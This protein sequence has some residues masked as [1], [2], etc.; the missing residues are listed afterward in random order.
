MS[1]LHSP[2]STPPDAAY[3]EPT[4]TKLA[5]PPAWWIGTEQ[6]LAAALRYRARGWSV[7]PLEPNGKKPL[8]KWQPFQTE[9]PHA[10]LLEAWWSEHKQANCGI[11]TGTVSGLVVLDVDGELGQASIADKHLPPTPVA[12]TAKGRHYY[13]RYPGGQP[14][15]NFARRLPGLDLR[16]EGGYVV[17]PPSIHA[18]GQR[19][20]WAE[21]L[22]P[23]DVELAPLPQWIVDLTK[24]ATTM[25]MTT[26]AAWAELLAC[27]VE[28]GQRNDTAARLAGHL[29]GKGLLEAEV[30][31][32]LLG[33][34]E[35]NKPPLAADEVQAVVS[36]VGK[37]EARKPTTT[38]TTITAQELMSREFPAPRW[39]VPGLLP[40][41][42][43]ILAGRPKQ[44][45]SFLALAWGIATATGG[46]ALG[47]EQVEQGSALYAAL[48]DSPRRLQERLV[49]LLGD[50]EDP[51]AKLHFV[52]RLP[53]LDQGGLE[54]LESWCSEHPDTRL[55]ALDTYAKARPPRRRESDL[56]QYDSDQ[57][58]ILQQFAFDHHLCLLVVH[59]ERKGL[60]D[61]WL[62]AVSGSTGL[63]GAADA[64]LLLRRARG[65]AD[66]ELLVTGRDMEEQSL[67]LRFDR[68]CWQLLGK[69]E[70]VQLSERR[71][72]IL[73]A[74][75]LAR[76]QGRRLTPKQIADELGAERSTVRKALS[77]MIADHQVTCEGD[78]YSP[79]SDDE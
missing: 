33:W 60:A 74:L 57:G 29:L 19:Y 72:E 37:A 64:V 18:S 47:R 34:N 79:A 25:A 78:S 10:D 12:V 48:E 46:R 30:V 21:C 52:T 43:A 8:V 27:G 73:Q 1:E 36:S 32:I 51:P 54:F 62:D 22:S 3:I 20:A 5:E 56:Y 13:F 11:V 61:D 70:E 41:G 58:T 77:R 75:Q 71:R 59:H 49:T 76:Q 65:Q 28:R 6:L 31:P 40:E 68:G 66:A 26:G 67:A 4:L 38:I 23:E 17:A 53:R 45:K 39:C 2:T 15:R 24:P 69:A 55:V 50:G 16:G 35:R 63:T 44:G 9:P 14:I 7:I 42:F